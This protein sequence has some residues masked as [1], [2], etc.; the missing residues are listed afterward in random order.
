[1]PLMLTVGAK[2]PV[3]WTAPEAIEFSQ[4]TIKSDIWAFGILLIEL[5]TSGATPY[6]GCV[7]FPVFLPARPR[8]QLLNTYGL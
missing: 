5:T 6:P 4:F 8:I 2:F 1:M 3:K 7:C